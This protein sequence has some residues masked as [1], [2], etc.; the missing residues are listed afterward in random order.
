MEFPREPGRRKLFGGA[1]NS[2]RQLIVFLGECGPIFP[3][4]PNVKAANI[5]WAEGAQSLE[6]KTPLNALWEE[7]EN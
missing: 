1:S 5:H 2:Q 6:H 3:K 4:L 7:E